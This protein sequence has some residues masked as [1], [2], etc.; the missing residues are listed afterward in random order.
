M[1]NI[2]F[3]IIIIFFLLLVIGKSEKH[4]V[5]LKTIWDVG[6]HFGTSLRNIIYPIFLKFNFYGRKYVTIWA[7]KINTR[8]RSSLYI[9]RAYFLEG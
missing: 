1:D 6:F 2:T 8:K 5:N 9:F 3:E 4:F 7:E